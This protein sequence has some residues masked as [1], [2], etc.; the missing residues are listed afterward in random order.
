MTDRVEARD[1]ELYL[2]GEPATEAE[3]RAALDADPTH[4]ASRALAAL[5]E[6]ATAIRDTLA[7]LVMT[8]VPNRPAETVAAV[9]QGG[10]YLTMSTLGNNDPTL[11]ALRAECNAL[12]TIADRQ[13]RAYTDANP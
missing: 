2:D 13:R 1:G 9:D 4:A 8:P 5:V 7:Y 10:A 11:V 6:E 3:V 12:A